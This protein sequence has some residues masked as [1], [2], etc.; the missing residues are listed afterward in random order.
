M[1]LSDTLRAAIRISRKR[2]Y[3][4]AHGIGVCPQTLSAWV[5][6]IYPVQPNDRRILKLA[7]LLGVPADD[8]FAE[9]T[10]P[11][12]LETRSERG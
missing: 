4:L 7:A 2:Q 11:L 8:A 6:G 1:R 5:N 3:E 9:D 12:S 10:A